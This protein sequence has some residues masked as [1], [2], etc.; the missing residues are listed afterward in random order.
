MTKDEARLFK[1]R[2][3]LVNDVII[4]EARGAP[5]SLRLG[6]LAVMFAA[7]YELGWSER[8]QTGEEEVRQRWQRLRWKLLA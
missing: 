2:W 7:G 1:Q 6:Q 3:Q 4:E 8:L 5:V